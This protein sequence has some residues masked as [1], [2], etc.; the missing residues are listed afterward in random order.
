MSSNQDA[1]F[2]IRTVSELTGVNAI[3]L[4]AWE[5]RYGLIQ[6]H[7]TDKGHR[8][9]SMRD[10]DFINDVLGV[11]KKGI[12]I[13]R[14]RH[15]LGTSKE[16]LA[17]DSLD[18]PEL[19]KADL[20][21]TL[22]PDEI[23]G[24]MWLDYVQ[25]MQTCV[26]KYDA[27]ALDRIYHELT[28]QYPINL[29]ASYVLMPLLQQSAEKSR[30]LAAVSGEYHFLL[31]YLR[32]RISAN[33]L[34]ENAENGQKKHSRR[35]LSACFDDEA[36]EVNLLLLGADLVTQ[37]YHMVFLGNR[38]KPDALPLALTRS[39]A[40]GLILHQ[41]P[42]SALA[43]DHLSALVETVHVPVFL[44]GELDESMTQR[45]ADMKAIVLSGDTKAS[46]TQINQ[47]FCDLE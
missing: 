19:P 38:V 29:V 5:R 14:V 46:V 32:S 34:K 11:L 25:R 40:H 28:S 9:Y 10:V 13:G 33:Y 1:L 24:N 15:L 21:Q 42:L 8:L 26:V 3:T 7:R 23:D 45:F 2:P 41:S 31:Q 20:K 17:D 18:S 6:P 43:M 35:L 12:S 27:T 30:G 44:S 39:S 4:R 16:P 37:G 47:A 36:G 22:L